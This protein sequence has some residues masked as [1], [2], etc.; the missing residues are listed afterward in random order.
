MSFVKSGFRF[1]EFT[2]ASSNFFIISLL[3]DRKSFDIK[4]KRFFL[5]FEFQISM[6]YNI[7]FNIIKALHFV[8]DVT[9]IILK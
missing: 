6:I 3:H 4:V 5:F 2:L 1:D 7:I 9:T 8:T